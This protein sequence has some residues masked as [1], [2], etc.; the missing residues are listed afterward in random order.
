MRLHVYAKSITNSID[1]KIVATLMNS[2]KHAPESDASTRQYMLTIKELKKTD[3]I[4][5]EDNLA[6]GGEVSCFY[7]LT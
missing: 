7:L 3:I 5:V 6:I 2:E 4:D 1:T